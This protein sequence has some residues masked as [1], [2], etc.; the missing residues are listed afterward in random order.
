MCCEDYYSVAKPGTREMQV[1]LKGAVQ[2][3]KQ[4]LK[5]TDLSSNTD[6]AASL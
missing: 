5:S 2:E 1:Q 6:A 4:L 3:Y